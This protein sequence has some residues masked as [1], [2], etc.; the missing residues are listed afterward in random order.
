MLKAKSASTRAPRGSKPVSQAFFTALEAVPEA[1]RA[2][3]AN[4]A[5]TMIRDELK[6]MRAKTKA[7]AA[8]IKAHTPTKP[9][10]VAKTNGKI[11]PVKA[12]GPKKRAI[13]KPREVP[14][15]A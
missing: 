13:P 1:S 11:T 7:S 6:A 12:A 2:A 3:V 8:K 10:R 14:A 9:K 15:A 5:H 4:A